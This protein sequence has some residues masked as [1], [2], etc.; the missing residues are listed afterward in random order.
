MP[1]SSAVTTKERTESRILL[2]GGANPGIWW[3]SVHTVVSHGLDGFVSHTCVR[4]HGLR[5]RSLA[6]F[7]YSITDFISPKDL[8]TPV[9]CLKSS[10]GFSTT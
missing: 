7:P 6:Q 8:R 9:C 3:E 1:S 10:T 5:L 2:T 4:R